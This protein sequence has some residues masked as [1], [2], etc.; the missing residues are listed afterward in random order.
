MAL[1][2]VHSAWSKLCVE[3]S[4]ITWIFL[5]SNKLELSFVHERI[6]KACVHVYICKCAYICANTLHPT[7]PI[8]IPRLPYTHAQVPS[9][10]QSMELG[11]VLK[12]FQK[13]VPAL[14]LLGTPHYIQPNTPYTVDDEVQ[15]VCKYL[16]ALQVRGEEG[17]DRLYREGE[18]INLFVHVCVFKSLKTDNLHTYTVGIYARKPVK[19]S[20]EPNLP[21]EEC[22]QLLK[23]YMPEHVQNTKITQSLFIKW[24]T[25]NHSFKP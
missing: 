20:L 7:L 22:Q 21:E 17:I 4:Y 23:H 18:G 19:F 25:H 1:T 13:E 11:E 3:V 14:G 9:R 2:N 6:N 24:E 15:L 16:K 10:D 8:T 12:H 5:R